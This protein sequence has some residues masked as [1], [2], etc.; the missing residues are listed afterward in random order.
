[1]GKTLTPWSAWGRYEAAAG[2]DYEAKFLL[3]NFDVVHW[4]P[5]EEE[6]FLHVRGGPHTAPRDRFDG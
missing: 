6:E 1:M 5:M 2:D 3:R 4:L